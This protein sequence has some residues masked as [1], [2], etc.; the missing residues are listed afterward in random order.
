MPT[1]YYQDQN[2][3]L[4]HG[5]CI[6]LAETWAQADTLVTDPPYGI[7][8]V[9]VANY[10][11]GNRTASNGSPIA[12][13]DSLEVRDKALEIWGT[14]PAA[15]FGTWRKPAPPKVKHRLIWW[16]QGQAPGPANCAFMLQDEEI[17]I[18]GEG[19]RKSSPPMRSVI[20]TKESR[21]VAV[22]QIGHPTPKPVA[23]AIS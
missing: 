19:W 4:Y 3:T 17:Y 20:A 10:T 13:D 16:K 23:N 12:N 21:S 8:W 2:I 15:V 7:K 5:D 6:D 14:K 18:L 22:Q 1:P 9:G 11:A